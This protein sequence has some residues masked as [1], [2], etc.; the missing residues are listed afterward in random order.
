MSA[1][2]ADRT[3]GYD[4]EDTYGRHDLPGDYHDYAVGHSY[5]YGPQAYEHPSQ[6]LSHRS[7]T[8][9]PMAEYQYDHG[10]Y[11]Y[12]TGYTQPPVDEPDHDRYED[13]FD[14]GVTEDGTP[15]RGADTNSVYG[16]TSHAG[17]YHGG[18]ATPNQSHLSD[19]WTADEQHGRSWD[20]DRDHDSKGRPQL[21]G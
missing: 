9:F 20:R 18:Y 6:Q 19:V 4:P 21:F 15:Y 1:E 12:P 7:R 3:T 16:G 10:E 13:Q 8:P 14:R 11:D 5:S 17:A 2:Y